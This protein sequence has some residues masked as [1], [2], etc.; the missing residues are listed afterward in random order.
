MRARRNR[1]VF[2]I[3][4]AVPRDIDPEINRL[5][6]AYVYD[7]DDLQ[8]VVEENLQDRRQA[9]LQGERIVEEAVLQFRQW[10]ESLAVV[11]TIV[12]L[13]GKLEGIARAELER[14]IGSLPHL[15]PEDIQALERMTAAMVNKTLHDPTLLL[16][17]EGCLSADRAQ[18][19]DAARKLFRLDD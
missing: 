12:A 1:P 16:K 8:Q 13:R 6:N 10:I 11:P 15:S 19:L 9:A 2:F 18:L 17:S 14:T 4:I 7:I 3:D 5:T